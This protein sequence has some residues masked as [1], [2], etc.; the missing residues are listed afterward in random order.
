MNLNRQYI[1]K[2]MCI[3]CKHQYLYFLDSDTFGT[4]H[5][6]EVHA[7]TQEDLQV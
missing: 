2:D 5:D 6:N 4:D 7:S 1:L 3:H